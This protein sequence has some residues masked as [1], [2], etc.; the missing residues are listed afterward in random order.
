MS[1]NNYIERHKRIL[2]IV[3]HLG[4]NKKKSSIPAF[5]KKRLS[6]SRIIFYK[7]EQCQEEEEDQLILK[8][9][10]V[11]SKPVKRKLIR[12]ESQ[13]VQMISDKY[14]MLKDDPEEN[15]AYHHIQLSLMKLQEQE[16]LGQFHEVKQNLRMSKT[17]YPDPITIPQQKVQIQNMFEKKCSQHTV[18]SPQENTIRQKINDFLYK[19]RESFKD[20]QADVS[21]YKNLK[22]HHRL[23]KQRTATYFQQ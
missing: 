12:S 10:E 14:D 22:Q 4:L 15:S 5:E 7:P 18:E 19:T 23:Y 20:F 11:L 21:N 16:I 17:S 13:L 9:K 2:N 8:A 3:S 6:Q 1:N